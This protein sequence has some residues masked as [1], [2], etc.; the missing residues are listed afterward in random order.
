MSN[1]R[2]FYEVLGVKRSDSESVIKKAYRQL[3][4]KYHPDKTSGDKIAEEAFKEVSEAWEILGNK[5]KRAQYD[6]WSTSRSKS[7]QGTA[8]NN[9]AQKE[10]TEKELFEEWQKLEEELNRFKEHLGYAGPKSQRVYARGRQPSKNK[11]KNGPILSKKLGIF[12]GVGALLISVA[13]YKNKALDANLASMKKDIKEH[14][15]NFK[16]DFDTISYDGRQSIIQLKEYLKQEKIPYHQDT[17]KDGHVVFRSAAPVN[18]QN[19]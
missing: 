12:M 11:T 15:Y 19:R 10:P 14:K 13:A 1:K 7:Y 3:A 8:T 17:L 2:D 5:D 4:I 9:S 16:K 18:Q 6:K